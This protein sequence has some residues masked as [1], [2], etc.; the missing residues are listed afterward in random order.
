[1][2]T[3]EDRGRLRGEAAEL[4]LV[5]PRWISHAFSFPFNAG[6]ARA[7]GAELERRGFARVWVGEELSGDDYWHVCGW[8]RPSLTHRTVANTRHQ[9]EQLAARHHG[10]YDGWR[11]ARTFE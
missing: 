11:H 3:T 5:E 1:M 10:T 4:P 9:M 6:G 7:M 2:L 8:R